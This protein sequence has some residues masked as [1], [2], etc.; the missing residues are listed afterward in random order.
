MND[1]DD[2]ATV[3]LDI[4]ALK[5]EMALK[6]KLGESIDQEIEF[7]IHEDTENNT[8]TTEDMKPTVNSSS[9]LNAEKEIIFFDYSSDYFTKLVPKLPDLH[10][11]FKVITT[12]PELNSILRSGKESIIIFHY[13]AAPKAVNQLSG[14]IKL[15]FKNAKTVIVAKGL[16]QDKA[17][18]HKKSKSG[19]NSYLSVPFSIK[20]FKNTIE[21][22]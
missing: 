10:Y 4:A 8:D 13:N 5:A 18:T 21:N 1:E 2:K 6:K 14:Q 17:Q 9:E 7:S 19:A 12:L 22:L 15:K 16:S 20:Q 11:T 3:V